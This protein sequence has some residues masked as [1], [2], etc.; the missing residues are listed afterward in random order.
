MAPLVQD[1][2]AEILNFQLGEGMLA[3]NVFIVGGVLC[4]EGAFLE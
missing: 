2:I 1:L 4:N 3:R